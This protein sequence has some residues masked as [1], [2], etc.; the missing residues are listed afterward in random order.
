MSTQAGPT[1]SQVAYGPLFTDLYQITMAQL[2]F[3]MGLHETEAQ[4]DHFF[5]RYPDY[6]NHQAGYCINAGLEWL[7]NW[8]SENQFGTEEI[9]YLRSL[10]SSSGA[11]LFD[12]DFLRWLREYGNFQ[13]LSLKAIPEGRVVHPHEPL[14]IVEGPLAI[15]QLL[16]TSLLNR[17][18]YQTLVATKASRMAESARGRPILEFGLRRAHERGA[19]AGSRAALVG[20]ADFTSNVAVSKM[21]GLDPKGTHAHS[22]VQFFIAMGMGEIDAFR[23]YAETYPDDCLLLVDTVNTLESGI[24][25]AIAVF[26]EL[27]QKGH[28]PVGVRLDSGDLAYLSIQSALQLNQAGFEEVSIVL[29][30]DLD[31]L[32]IWQIITQISEE[33]PRYGLDATALVNRLVYG[34]GTRLITSW[35]EPALGGVYK[36]VAV[37]SDEG[38]KSAIKISDSPAKMPNPGQKRVT[39]LYD[40]RGYA[41]AD[42]ISLQEEEVNV[43]ENF[44]LRHPLSHSKK[45]LISAGEISQGEDLLI[46]ILKDGKLVY[47]L[48]DLATIREQRKQDLGR[49]DSGIRRL[50]NPHIYHVSLSQKLW[51]L[52]NELIRETAI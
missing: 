14:S 2:Y 48:P 12:D 23:A 9:N 45:R 31:E 26:E 4:F 18:N 19:N 1:S 21:V 3:R 22:M 30:G 41:T 17:M 50:V 10:E 11:R 35:G 13:S 40:S 27:R 51:E 16:E 25:N 38:W 52:K 8:M 24:P 39:R 44:E 6:G 49:L 46:D 43:S 7:V 42:S 28:R 47:D 29:S 36:L 15:A 32:V 20:G 5:R 33:A 37:K 34:A